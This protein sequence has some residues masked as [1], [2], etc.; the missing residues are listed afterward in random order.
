[1]W[2]RLR[3][4][5]VAQVEGAVLRLMREAQLLARVH[6]RS[7]ARES[8]HRTIITRAAPN[9]VWASDQHHDSHGRGRPSDRV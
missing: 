1:V 6:A 4:E 7:R 3:F 2:A 8:A 9:E 5:G